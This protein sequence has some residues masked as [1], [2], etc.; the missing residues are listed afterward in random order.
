M[1]RKAYA[2]CMILIMC[3]SLCCPAYASFFADVDNPTCYASAVDWAVE[4]GITSGIAA[5]NFEP[6]TVCTEAEILTFIHRYMGTPKAVSSASVS[7]TA[8]GRYYAEAVAWACEQKVVDG[9]TFNAESLCTRSKAVE[10]LWKLAGRPATGDIEFSDVPSDAAYAQAVSWAVEH[11]ITNGTSATTFSPDGVCSRGQ[12][13]A[14]LYRYDALDAASSGREAD[15]MDFAAKLSEI[16]RLAAEAKSQFEKGDH[17]PLSEPVPYK[18][19]W[20]GYTHVTYQNLDFRMTDF[21]RKYLEAVV[22]NFE[23]VVEKY[24]GHNVD[25]TIDLH[26]IDKTVPLTKDPNS[27]WLHLAKETAQT[28]IDAYTEQAYYDTVLTTVQTKGSE[29]ESRNRNMSGYGV[30]DVMLGLEFYGLESQMGYS[31]FNLYHPK[32]GIDQ[33][34]DPS[35]PVLYATSV[36][37]HEW[38]HQLEYLG[39]LLGIEYPN[40]HA[41]QGPEYPGYEAVY[42]DAADD[43]KLCAFYEAVLGGTVPFTDEGGNTRNVGIYPTMWRLVKRDALDAGSVTIQSSAGDSYLT[44]QT[45]EPTVTTAEHAC[46]WQIRYGGTKGCILIPETVPEKQLTLSNAWDL[47]GNPLHMFQP[48]PNYPEAQLWQLTKNTNGTYCI[49]TAYSSGRAVTVENSGKAA[50]IQ[51]AETPKE[52]QTWI[53]KNICVKKARIAYGQ[54]TAAGGRNSGELRGRSSYSNRRKSKGDV[55]H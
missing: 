33:M 45:D 22:L 23:K 34:D 2:C 38:L 51:T 11:G 29:N 53:I 41:Y 19:L 47:E 24:S 8:S 55:E 31:T 18:I 3:L 32:K 46:I 30:Y 16:E 20:L 28:D 9:E 13:I 27:N 1:K 7:D 48:N 14:L 10:Y 25:I 4:K 5:T 43:E 6:E 37:L 21:D 35:E 36:A 26:F 15:S 39:E 50:V 49:R 42:A 12:I 54:P 44:G 52:T 17:T 40:T